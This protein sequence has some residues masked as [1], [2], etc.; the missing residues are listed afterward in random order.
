MQSQ[1]ASTHSTHEH[2]C[3]GGV[4]LSTLDLKTREME[5][6]VTEE[7]ACHSCEL[8]RQ[9]IKRQGNSQSV[10]FQMDQI[11]CGLLEEAVCSVEM[12]Y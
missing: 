9:G 8:I 5:G 1:T 10:D 2:E 12:I 6:K 11:L 3:P 7:V 4:A